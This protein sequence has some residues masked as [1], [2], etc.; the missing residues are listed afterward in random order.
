MLGEIG[1]LLLAILWRSDTHDQQ[2]RWDSIVE[3]R[4]K[5]DDARRKL[6]E[7]QTKKRDLE[8]IREGLIWQ[9]DKLLN[10]IRCETRAEARLGEVATP[11]KRLRSMRRK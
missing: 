11:M 4:R 9:F 3:A 10:E 7:L 1:R 5:L 2:R 6:N 8:E